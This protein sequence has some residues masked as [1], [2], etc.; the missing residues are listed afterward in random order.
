MDKIPL[1]RMPGTIGGVDN[2]LF[3]PVI[4]AFAVD[5]VAWKESYAW[6]DA[7]RQWHIAMYGKEVVP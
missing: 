3:V 1:S 7:L 2:S 4:S 5:K 6:K